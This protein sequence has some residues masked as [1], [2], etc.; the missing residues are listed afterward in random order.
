MKIL[1]EKPEIEI[2]RLNCTDIICTSG[3]GADL[4]GGDGEAEEM[5]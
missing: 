2:I 3:M 4:A 1:F 5:P